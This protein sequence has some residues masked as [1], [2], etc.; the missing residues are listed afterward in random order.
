MEKWFDPAG[1]WNYLHSDVKDV[2][3]ST[4]VHNP[5]K[6]QLFINFHV[7]RFWSAQNG[8]KGNA[9]DQVKKWDWIKVARDGQSSLCWMDSKR[10]AMCF[11][12]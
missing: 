7:G 1:T 9:P 6:G 12:L 4:S 10:F 3:S 5:N 11:N 8:W 2:R